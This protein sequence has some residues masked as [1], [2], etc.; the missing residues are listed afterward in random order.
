MTRLASIHEP[1]RSG[2]GSGP[3]SRLDWKTRHGFRTVPPSQILGTKVGLTR[4]NHELPSLAQL[5]EC[6][7]EKNDPAHAGCYTV[8]AINQVG[9]GCLALVWRR[10]PLLSSSSLVLVPRPRISQTKDRGRGRRTKDEDESSKR[11]DIPLVIMIQG[12]IMPA[13]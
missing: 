8:Q 2:D 12:R 4:P 3:L 7:A 9:L 10:Q 13:S 11:P 1:T 6:S 5:F